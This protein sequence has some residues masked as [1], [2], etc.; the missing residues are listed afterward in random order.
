MRRTH[1]PGHFP[2]LAGVRYQA[3]EGG[4]VMERWP[5]STAWVSRI[6]GQEDFRARPEQ[7][8]EQGQL[9]T[10]APFRELH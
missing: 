1:G 7:G 5:T 2:P 4:G 8:Q 9:P 6:N 10:Q 3:G